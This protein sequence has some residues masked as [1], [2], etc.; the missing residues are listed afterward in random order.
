LNHYNTAP[1]APAGHNEL[2]PLHL[3]QKQIRQIIAFLKTLDSPID[4]ESKWL[5]KP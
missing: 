5:T 3:T 4:A 2:E 1:E